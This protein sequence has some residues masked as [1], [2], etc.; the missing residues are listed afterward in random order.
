MWKNVLMF[1]V[2]DYTLTCM[3][4]YFYESE[5]PFFYDQLFK[6]LLFIFLLRMVLSIPVGVVVLIAER[7]LVLKGW[8]VR[9]GFFV[10]VIIA[11][12]FVFD[13]PF[14]LDTKGASL[15]LMAYLPFVLAYVLAF[16]VLPDKI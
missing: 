5:S 9:I 2:L 1:I 7:V 12:F 8:S 10:G 6:Y 16:F 13:E 15:I 3:L 4:C 14:Q 11:G